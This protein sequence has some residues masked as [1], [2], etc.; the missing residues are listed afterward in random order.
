MYNYSLPLL[1]LAHAPRML[2]RL[3]ILCGLLPCSV[4]GAEE[5]ASPIATNTQPFA[6]GASRLVVDWGE[7]GETLPREPRDVRGE[8][9]QLLVWLQ[10]P[11]MVAFMSEEN[12]KAVIQERAAATVQAADWL[13]RF[14]HEAQVVSLPSIAFTSERQAA[15]PQWMHAMPIDVRKI[16]V[17][18]FVDAREQSQVDWALRMR[19]EKPEMQLFAVGYSSIS[20]IHILNEQYPALQ[21]IPK[22]SYPGSPVE[23][24]IH[25]FSVEAL[26]A[27]VA[28]NGDLLVIHEGLP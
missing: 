27:T 4:F 2:R 16:V 21:F 28:V 14:Y 5:R 8:H 1:G 15:I 3:C 9:D 10:S 22:A 24:W 17:L 18:G 23:N 19:K 12:R 7:R 25:D 6:D 26:P 13:D 11:D 20:A